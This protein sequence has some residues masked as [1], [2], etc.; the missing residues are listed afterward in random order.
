M[1]PLNANNPAHQAARSWAAK[2]GT[3]AT[4]LPMI[5]PEAAS[6]QPGVTPPAF[7][8]RLSILLNH[9]RQRRQRRE[10]AAAKLRAQEFLAG[11]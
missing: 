2:L 4:E 9:L 8:S 7:P 1:N 11:S 5:R 10:H 6:T 3:L